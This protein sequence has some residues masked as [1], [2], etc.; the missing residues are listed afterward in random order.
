LV[1]AAAFGRRFARK[2][3]QLRHSQVTPLCVLRGG[4][5]RWRMQC[6]VLALSALG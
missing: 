3:P 1:N 6:E 5:A 4:G 2:N